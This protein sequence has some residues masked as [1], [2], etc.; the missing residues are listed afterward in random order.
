MTWASERASERGLKC[1][2]PSHP[3][4]SSFI[5]ILLQDG[6]LGCMVG[7]KIATICSSARLWLI[8]NYEHLWKHGLAEGR[9][10]SVIYYFCQYWIVSL[11]KALFTAVLPSSSA[12]ASLWVETAL[13]IAKTS[14]TSH[15]L[16][17][18]KSWVSSHFIYG[19]LMVQVL[20]FTL[21]QVTILRFTQG[22]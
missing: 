3:N 14:S 15:F 2:H 9:N 21:V 10:F 22:I 5:S 20:K 7:M 8:I 12:L 1:L 13:Q 6:I 16:V 19:R 11:E 18:P 4:E 17:W